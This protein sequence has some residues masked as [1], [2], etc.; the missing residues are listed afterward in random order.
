VAL[1]VS[2]KFTDTISAVAGYR[3]LGVNYDNDGFVFD[4]VQQGPI[5]G[6][7]IH[8]DDT[9]T[10]PAMEASDATEYPMRRRL[11]VPAF[12]FSVDR[13][14]GFPRGN[15]TPGRAPEDQS[16]HSHISV[17]CCT[18]F[19]QICY[20]SRVRWVAVRVP[21]HNIVVAHLIS[22]AA[23][24]SFLFGGAFFSTIYFRHLPE[25]GSLSPLG[26]AIM[27]GVS[28]ASVLFGLYC[29]SLELERFGRA[30]EKE[31]R[32]DD[33]TPGDRRRLSLRRNRR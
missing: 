13:L 8:S 22:F 9:D 1:A 32:E 3:A 29:Y 31:D 17:L 6:V 26:R 24:L 14:P 2:Y 21:F 5:I 33:T 15:D 11:R 7:A 28:I 18:L 12:R 16:V 19:L 30:I 25:L 23:R 4:V 27:S 20:W 10:R